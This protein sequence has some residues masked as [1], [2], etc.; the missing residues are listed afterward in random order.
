MIYDV[1]VSVYVY[2][3]HVCAVCPSPSLE[4]WPPAAS[5]IQNEAKT[6]IKKQKLNSSP[7]G[8]KQVNIKHHSLMK[9]MMRSHP[10]GALPRTSATRLAA[11][12]ETSG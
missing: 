9:L 11:G 7:C 4:C 3:Y 6:N 12:E 2:V 8:E 5:V 1:S 10:A